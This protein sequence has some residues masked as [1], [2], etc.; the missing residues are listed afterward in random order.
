MNCRSTDAGHGWMTA[1]AKWLMAPLLGFPLLLCAAA[2]AQE[3]F[4][5]PAWFRTAA[6][7]LRPAVT[8]NGSAVT[9]RQVARWSD[10][11]AP[12]LDAAADLVVARLDRNER[13]H[14][15]ELRD[16]KLVLEG[17][18]LNLATIN[19]RGAAACAVTAG[20]ETPAPRSVVLPEAD[21]VKFASATAVVSST[22]I[23]PEA[24]TA[25][26]QVRSLRQLL[27]EELA[28]RFQLPQEDMAVRFNPQDERLLNLSEPAYSFDIIPRR[29]RNLGDITWD[30]IVTTGGGKQQVAI[31]ANVRAWQTQLV[32][33]RPIAT[34]QVF[35]EG[36]LLERR[37]LADRI[38]DQAPLRKEQA[39]GQQAARDIS[40]G[41]PLANAM[42]EAVQMIK[43][44]ELVTVTV[45]NGR[46]Q[47]KWIAEAREHGALGQS[48][49]VRKPNTREEFSVV[50]TGPQ[51]AQLV[52]PAGDRIA[53]K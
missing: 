42:V 33:T 16:V 48:I 9:L 53:G 22:P 14:S 47:L 32:A 25:A 11:D 37:V 6:V 28:G 7:E 27:L 40:A 45:F 24:R 31:T 3:K 51:Q 30:V 46:I 21:A 5:A 35:T 34:K 15:V 29:Q 12:M 2:Q 8:V 50:V 20:A 44:G 26:V 43:L 4:I 41:M 19:F 52:G 1:A 18:G 39:V 10:A 38:S 13:Q 17:A 49:R 23:A 36:D